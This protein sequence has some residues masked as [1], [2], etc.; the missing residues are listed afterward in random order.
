VPMAVAP[1]IVSDLLWQR[2]EP[3]LSKVER[4]FG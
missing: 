4:R 3:L 2:I 1:C